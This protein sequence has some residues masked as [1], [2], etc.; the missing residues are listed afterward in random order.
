MLAALALLPLAA[1]GGDGGDDEAAPTTATSSATTSELVATTTATAPTAADLQPL[2]DELQRFV[3]RERGLRF[4]KPVA[5]RLAGDDEFRARL[6][7]DAEEDVEEVEEVE[8]ILRALGLLQREVDLFE[9]VKRLLGETVVGVYFPDTDEL[10]VRAGDI[11]P[12][13]RS[14]MVHELTHALQDQHFD[15]DRQ[16][17]DDRKDET[18]LGFSAVVEGDAVTVEE[19]YRET[20]SRADRR[21]YASEE[22]AIGAGLDLEGIPDVVVEV[23]AAPYVLGPA[24]VRALREAGGQPRLDEAFRAPPSTT[25]QLVDPRRYLAGEQ[26]APVATPRADGEPIDDDMFG[27]L[28]LFLVLRE[29]IDDD[30]ARDAAAGWGGDHYVAWRDGE[31]TC[32]RVTFVMDSTRD[33]SELTGALARWARARPAADLDADPRSAT[34]TTCD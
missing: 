27:Q 25:E 4:R 18:A 23:I 5:V 12:Y 19:A 31:R 9:A 16:E 34:L 7:R 15:I 8:G 13:A 14:T 1:C 26:A 33:L 3:E 22:A 21:R 30:E 28:F 10:W 24:L 32:I 20:F 11:T 6:L 29:E 17:Y 2:V